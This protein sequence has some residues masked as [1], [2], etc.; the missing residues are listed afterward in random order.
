MSANTAM[1]IPSS[2]RITVVAVGPPNDTTFLTSPVSADPTTVSATD[3]S[4]PA[5]RVASTNRSAILAW[6]NDRL[7]GGC[8]HTCSVAVR[9][10]LIQPRPVNA[11]PTRPMTPSPA[12]LSIAVLTASS[13]CL[14][15]RPAPGTGCCRAASAVDPGGT[16]ARSRYGDAQQDQGD[17]RQEADEG[18]CAG[19]QRPVGTTQLLPG[20]D[21]VIQ[22]RP[23]G[24][25]GLPERHGPVLR[26][27]GPVLYGHGRV[28]GVLGC[29]HCQFLFAHALI[30][31][32][33]RSSAAEERSLR[34]SLTTSPLVV[35]KPRGPACADPHGVPAPRVY[36]WPRVNICCSVQAPRSR[37]NN[38]N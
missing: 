10:L 32:S 14:R 8:R 19:Q 26:G 22:P 18:Q 24:P 16:A 6:T 38:A 15:A 2:R 36:G 34:C 33:F 11:T 3:T 30:G 29:A 4:S 5:P 1:P 7:S 9:R 12:R 27:N 23:P 37:V 25:L 35:R 31:Y 13:G 21:R 20:A 28:P 17:Q